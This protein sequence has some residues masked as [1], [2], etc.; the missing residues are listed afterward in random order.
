MS[1]EGNYQYMVK[2]YSKRYAER[3]ILEIIQK[4]N[5]ETVLVNATS[6]FLHPKSGGKK[7]EDRL[8]KNL[9]KKVKGIEYPKN[10]GKFLC[11]KNEFPCEE[12]EKSTKRIDIMIEFEKY[13]IAIEAKVDAKLVN[14]LHKYSDAIKDRSNGRKCSGLVL[15]KE[16]IETTED[17]I[18][19][20]KKKH[21][22][23]AP[24]QKHY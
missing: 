2:Y 15:I 21:E 13:C 16:N 18:E 6:F 17:Y 12:D 8:L 4:E 7:I 1:N 22:K 10:T 19:E 5:S 9:M 11:M 20:M 14:P 23:N 3:N 24:L